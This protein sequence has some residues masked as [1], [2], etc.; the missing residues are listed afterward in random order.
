MSAFSESLKIRPETP[1]DYPS[2]RQVNN[3]AFDSDAEANLVD[4]LRSAYTIALS[5][6]AYHDRMIVGHI[7]FSTLP[8]ETDKHTLR[9]VSLAPMAVLPQFQR[10]G[11]G[12]AL[13]EQGLELCRNL[14]FVAVV[15]LGHP[16]YYTRFGFSSNLARSIRS[17]YSDLGSA[18]MAIE[19]QAGSLQGIEGVAHY[20]P[21]FDSLS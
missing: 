4:N 16:D 5:F 10:Q 15:V 21:A 18:W 7:G 14:G 8:I 20:A 13:I 17:P 6:V 12:T 1:T 11:V 9:A 2:I 19:L 3:L